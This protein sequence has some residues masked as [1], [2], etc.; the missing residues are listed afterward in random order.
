M[1]IGQITLVA[2]TFL[3][4]CFLSFVNPG[5]YVVAH[6]MLNHLICGL[7]IERETGFQHELYKEGGNPRNFHRDAWQISKLPPKIWLV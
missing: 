3:L 5:L 6:G 1:L 4:V 2:T 7:T